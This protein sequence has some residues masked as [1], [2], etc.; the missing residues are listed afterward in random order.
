MIASYDQKNNQVS[1]IRKYGGHT[2]IINDIYF[3]TLHSQSIFTV[4]M[5]KRYF[6]WNLN[7]DITK[8]SYN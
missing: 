1:Y 7:G 3:G 4:G 8:Y 6:G 5:D 2:D